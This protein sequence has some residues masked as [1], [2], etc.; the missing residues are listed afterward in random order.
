MLT[1][2]LGKLVDL[3]LLPG[4]AH[5]LKVLEALIE[6]V[7]FDAFIADKAYDADWLLDK[8]LELNPEMKVVIPSKSNRE[9]RRKHDV[10]MYKRI[11][12]S[13]NSSGRSR[14]NGGS[15]RDSTRPTA[16]TRPVSTSWERWKP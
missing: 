1:D 10:E 4:Q 8:L 5:K 15:L 14:K 16:V 2:D 6:G 3:V 7:T 9:T 13:R 11:V 12:W